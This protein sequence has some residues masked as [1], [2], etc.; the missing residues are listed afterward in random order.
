MRKCEPRSRSNNLPN[1]SHRQLF[2]RI[3]IKSQK[4]VAPLESSNFP[5]RLK[6]L[7][8][9]CFTFSFLTRYKT[10]KLSK[11]QQHSSG[12]YFSIYSPAGLLDT[13]QHAVEGVRTLFIHRSYKMLRCSAASVRVMPWRVLNSTDDNY[14]SHGKTKFYKNIFLF[15]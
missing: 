5:M 11:M 3:I 1:F 12:R 2:F 14:S 15:L 6:T 4:S 13:S 9:Q 10:A 7:V 8:P